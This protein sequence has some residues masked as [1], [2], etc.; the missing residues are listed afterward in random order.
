VYG[1]GILA[2]EDVVDYL[3]AEYSKEVYDEQMPPT[4][5]AKKTKPLGIIEDGDSVIMY[6]FRS[7]RSRQLTKAFVVPGYAGI[8]HQ[9]SFKDLFF[10]T[11]T[12][13]EKNLPVEILYAP[14]L[15]TNPLAKVISDAGLTQYHIAET[16]KYAHV[17]FFLNGGTE[18]AFPGEDRKVIPSPKVDSYDQKPE[19]RT[20]EIA[21]EIIAS[22]Q[23]QTHDFI[24]ANIANP[25]MVAHTGN[26]EATITAIESVDKQIGRIAEAVLSQNGL[27][28]I[29]ADHGNAEELLNMASQSIDKEHSTNPVPLIIIA[30]DLEGKNLGLPEGVGGDLSTIPPSGVLADVAPTILSLMGVDVPPEMTGTPLL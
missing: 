24:V 5:F 1:K 12:E 28:V 3:D 16:E 23:K 27:L 13:Y 7:D 14:I 2:T 26:L 10:A 21:D 30:K 18:K 22:V 15:I 29:T 17:T 9:K 4:V 19:M 8:D 25:D 11:M 20:K 6:N